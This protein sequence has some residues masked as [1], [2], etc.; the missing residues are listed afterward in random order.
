MTLVVERNFTFSR[1]TYIK[2][3]FKDPKFYTIAGV[4]IDVYEMAK[5]KPVLPNIDNLRPEFVEKPIEEIRISMKGGEVFEKYSMP[6]F[7]DSN[8][9][10]QLL[11]DP[12]IKSKKWLFQAG[13]TTSES[14]GIIIDK[15]QITDEPEQLALKIKY[16]Y[17]GQILWYEH[18]I[19]IKID[20]ETVQQKAEEKKPINSHMSNLL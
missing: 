20:F 16:R 1:V 8:R 6:K 10:I 9:P 5:E 3:A 14:F 13:S 18:T 11:L 2:A 17:E 4:Q 15:T 19:L 12:L 7:K